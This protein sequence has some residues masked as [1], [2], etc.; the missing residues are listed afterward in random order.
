MYWITEHQEQPELDLWEDVR[1]TLV[2]QEKREQEEAQ[3]K[4][5]EARNW[6]Y[7]LIQNIFENAGGEKQAIEGLGRV[8]YEHL[9]DEARLQ[10]TK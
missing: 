9:R 6:F 3:K 1:Y 7:A 10:L 5:E 8:A 4:I 2:M